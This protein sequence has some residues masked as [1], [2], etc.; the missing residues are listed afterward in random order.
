MKMDLYYKIYIFKNNKS[1]EPNNYEQTSLISAREI[2]N[3]NKPTKIKAKGIP[4][5]LKEN[6][7]L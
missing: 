4:I 1:K 6:S 2:V 3:R 7:H 5:I